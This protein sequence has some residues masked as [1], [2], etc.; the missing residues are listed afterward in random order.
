MTGF[1]QKL[2]SVAA[3]LMPSKPTLVRYWY[4]IIASVV[5]TSLVE[6]A[7]ITQ[8]EFY[9][10]CI[11]IAF[12]LLL[13]HTDTCTHVHTHTHKP[14]SGLKCCQRSDFPSLFS[15]S[16]FFTLFHTASTVPLL[17]LALSA[18]AYRNITITLSRAESTVP[19][20]V[21]AL[22]AIA[23][24]NI[25]ITLSRAESPVPLLILAFS[26]IA[27]KNNITI[28]LFHAEST[29]P[30]LILALS[31]IAYRNNIMITSFH[32]ESTV[33]LTILALSAIAYRNNWVLFAV[34]VTP[35]IACH[36][37]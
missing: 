29:F 28:T 35:S 14:S 10:D 12:C 33:S 13:R 6:A 36:K 22:S 31:A 16:W 37:K 19:L 3:S 23:Y 7:V 8:Y 27:Y 34:S 17:I 11:H 26:A 32:A 1:L 4:F 30:L 25:T 5:C 2:S 20:L 24:R 9:S 21:L 18:I 15:T